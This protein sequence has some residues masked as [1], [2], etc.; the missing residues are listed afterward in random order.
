MSENSAP[1]TGRRAHRDAIERVALEL[2]ESGGP[3]AVTTRAVAAAANVQAVAIYRAYGDMGA[4]LDAAVQRG[5]RQYLEL[6]TDRTRVADPVDDLRHG[7]DLHVG[8]G[9]EHPHLYALMYGR[10]D[11][12]PPGAAAAQVDAVLL[13]LVQAVA[14]AGR[15]RTDVASAARAVHAAGC[16]VALSM[17]G[18]PLADRDPQLSHRVRE[19]VLSSLTTDVSGVPDRS[20]EADGRAVYAIALAASLHDGA[21]SSLTEAETNLLTE[22]LNRIEREPR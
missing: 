4:L 16:G 14:R 9:L 7:W 20:T 2:L 17:I 1:A 21:P 22:W 12:N 6:K 19:A 18:V 5:F 8:F 13:E 15:L 3:S 11:V 10:P